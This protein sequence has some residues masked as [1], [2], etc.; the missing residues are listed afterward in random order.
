MM[1]GAFISIIGYALV[2]GSD[3]TQTSVR[4]GAMFVGAS[5]CFLF[6]SLTNAQ[7]S[8]NV[9]SDTSRSSVSGCSG[10]KCV[11]EKLT[12]AGYGTQHHDGKSRRN[13]CYVELSSR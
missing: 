2:L 6:G 4:Y 13:D 1:A 3:Y 9:L 10:L 12:C 7:I 5:G 11:D 8:A